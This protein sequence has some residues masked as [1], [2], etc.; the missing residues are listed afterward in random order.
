MHFTG[1]FSWGPQIQKRALL[2]LCSICLWEYNQKL[3]GSRK[4]TTEP[5]SPFGTMLQ[6][7]WHCGRG[8]K[9]DRVIQLNCGEVC[10]HASYKTTRTWENFNNQGTK[11]ILL[12]DKIWLIS[13]NSNSFANWSRSIIRHNLG[14]FKHSEIYLI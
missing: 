1:K 10:T 2:E 11:M 8:A 13:N 5:V 12:L 7:S 3:S 9:P 14:L 4:E 6:T